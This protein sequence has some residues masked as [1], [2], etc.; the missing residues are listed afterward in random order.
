M[1][2]NLKSTV[3]RKHHVSSG[4]KIK[5]KQLGEVLPPQKSTKLAPVPWVDCCP[6]HGRQ[7]ICPDSG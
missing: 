6:G 1:I 3:E 7:A 2:L 4:F 5:K